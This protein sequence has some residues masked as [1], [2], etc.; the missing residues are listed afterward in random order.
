MLDLEEETL[1]ARLPVG[2]G[3]QV[4]GAVHE[5]REFGEVHAAAALREPAVGGRGARASLDLHP[6][7]RG[8]GVDAGGVALQDVAQ[9]DL[10]LAAEAAV[11][12][13]ALLLVALGT[14]AFEDGTGEVLGRHGSYLL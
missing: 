13:S 7:Q 8:Q 6:A 2:E 14:A 12:R 11:G 4:E 3:A 10:G 9:R 5:T 1:S